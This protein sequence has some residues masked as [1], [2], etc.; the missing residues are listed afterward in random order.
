MRLS[1]LL[2]AVVV[3]SLAGCLHARPV[4][5]GEDHESNYP[6]PWDKETKNNKPL[7]GILAQACHN[8]PGR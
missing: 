8:C 5:T 4:T 2:L 1:Q 3:V 6:K 7:I